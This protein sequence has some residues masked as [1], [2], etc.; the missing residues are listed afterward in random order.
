[1]IESEQDL[2]ELVHRLVQKELVNAYAYSNLERAILTRLLVEKIAEEDYPNLSLQNFYRSSAEHLRL[3]DYGNH[4]AITEEIRRMSLK[5]AA[6]LFRD[7]ESH[8]YSA[9]IISEKKLRVLD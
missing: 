9:R 1:M 3:A 8:L 4:D 6:D 5:L 2:E 7:V